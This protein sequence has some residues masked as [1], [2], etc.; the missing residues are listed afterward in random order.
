M[1]DK[2]RP[3]YVERKGYL[4]DLSSLTTL[5]HRC[6]PELCTDASVCCAEHDVWVDRAERDRVAEWG[7][8][9]S[10]MFD[11]VDQKLREVGDPFRQLGPDLFVLARG[12]EGICVWAYRG[13]KGEVLCALHSAA[14]K[15]GH[16]PEEAKPEGCIL[17][18]LCLCG[19]APPEV[20][21]QPGA[22]QFPCNTFVSERTQLHG[23]TRDLLIRAGILEPG[24]KLQ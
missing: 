23:G 8:R 19:D 9:A 14:L 13:N 24:E 21:V 3:A 20:S 1:R 4:L 6:R 7:S 18:P 5:E 12:S 11:S 10:R 16:S 22:E 2:G 15:L 17:W